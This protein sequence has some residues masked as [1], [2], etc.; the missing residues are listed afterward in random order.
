[1][2][3]ILYFHKLLRHCWHHFFNNVK[4]TIFHKLFYIRVILLSQLATWVSCGTG[5]INLYIIVNI[6]I[7]SWYHSLLYINYNKQCWLIT[8]NIYV[9]SKQYRL[10]IMKNAIHKLINTFYWEWDLNTYAR[11]MSVRGSTG[12]IRITKYIVYQAI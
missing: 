6:I 4:D 1:M 3:R 12:V 8:N 2:I 7:A 9:N 11:D 5:N 10:T